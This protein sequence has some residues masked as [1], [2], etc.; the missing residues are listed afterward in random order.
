MFI[1]LSLLMMLFLFI[2]KFIGFGVVVFGLF[3]ELFRV[4]LGFVIFV[5]WYFVSIYFWGCGCLDLSWVIK[6][7]LLLLVMNNVKMLM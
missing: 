5:V 1:K 3:S 7:L 2:I 6:K 4:R